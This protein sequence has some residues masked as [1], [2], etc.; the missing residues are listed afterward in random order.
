MLR[1]NLFDFS[2]TYIVGKG[3]IEHQI[4]QSKTNM[5]HLEIMHHLFNC[6]SKISGV[7]INNA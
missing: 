6:F 1:A 7:Q 5:L 4:M 2:D 3:T